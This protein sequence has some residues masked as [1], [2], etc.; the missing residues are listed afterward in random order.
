MFARSLLMHATEI[1]DDN[2]LAHSISQSTG[3]IRVEIWGA[4]ELGYVAPASQAAATQDA[5]GKVHERSKKAINHRI[6]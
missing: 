4:I 5:Y 3:E 1:D 6:E 2:Y